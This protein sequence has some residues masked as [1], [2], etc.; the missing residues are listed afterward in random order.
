MYALNVVVWTYC[1]KT[2]IEDYLEIEK[3]KSMKKAINRL[4]VRI[5]QELDYYVRHTKCIF[6]YY[7]KNH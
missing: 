7:D 1:F 3:S 2:D 6:D 4:K 5:N